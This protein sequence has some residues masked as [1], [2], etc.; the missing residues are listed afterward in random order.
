MKQT[1][2]ILTR[3]RYDNHT[4]KTIVKLTHYASFKI[5]EDDVA[6]R[7]L[8]SSLSL[9]EIRYLIDIRKA[10]SHHYTTNQRLDRILNRALVLSETDCF[11]LKR[12]AVNGNDLK[13]FGLKNEKIGSTLTELL[14]A[15]IADQMLNKKD[16]L[17]D[18]AKNIITE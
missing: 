8:L 1:E 4:I 17:L 3:M 5:D 13:A 10:Y 6:I 12:L 18:I 14:N 2:E 16:I 7:Q 15:V 9:N 11:T